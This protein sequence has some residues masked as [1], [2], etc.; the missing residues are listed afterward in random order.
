MKRIIEIEYHNNPKDW[1]L[2]DV[3]HDV[4]L[5]RQFGNA[6]ITEHKCKD[7]YE[8]GF[9]KGFEDGQHNTDGW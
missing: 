7:R 8:E 9:K 2:L 5:D 6:V 1:D 3:I 4:L